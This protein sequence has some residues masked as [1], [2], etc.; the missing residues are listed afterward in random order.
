M[1]SGKKSLIWSSNKT[2]NETSL[3]SK[4]K[5]VVCGTAMMISFLDRYG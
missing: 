3:P 5:T 1:P 4:D 2:E